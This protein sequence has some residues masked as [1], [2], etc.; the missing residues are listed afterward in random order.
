MDIPWRAALLVV[1]AAFVVFLIAKLLPVASR[2]PQG[3]S[4]L[5]GAKAR[6]REATT[7]RD[8]ALALCDAGDAALALPFGATRAAAYF[9]GAMRADPEWAGS[10]ERAAS[11]LSGRRP[12]LLEKLLWRRLAATPWDAAH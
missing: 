5:S 4:A 1:A 7:A 9:L 12:R 8:R 6:A 3:S 11:A 10:V 2:G